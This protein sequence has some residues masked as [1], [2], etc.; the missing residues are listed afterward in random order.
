[1]KCPRCNSENPDTAYFCGACGAQLRF[2]ENTN[3]SQTETLEVSGQ[4]LATGTLFAGRYQIIEELG[5]G[6]MG[7]VY[8]AL[9][10]KLNE[11]VAL[12]LIR[13]E[14]AAESKTLERFQNELK[15]ARRISHRNIGR[16]YE[17]MEEK[18]THFITMEY[19]PGE[20]LKSAIRRFGQLPVGKCLFIARQICE[21]LAEAHRLGVVHRDLKP[22]NIMIDREGNARILDFGIARSLAEKGI[23]GEG[24]MIGTPE[25]MSPE[26]AEAR[27]VDNR[28]DIY[29]LGILL[30]E[31]LTGRVPFEGETPLGVAMKQKT[32]APP[33]PK[34]LN[35]QVPEGLARLVLRCLEKDKARRYQT[36]E[37][38]LTDLRAV[39]K[40]IPTTEMR[41][42][43][44]PLTS[45]EITFTFRVKKFLVPALAFM[46]ILVIGFVLLKVLPRKEAGG[47]PPGRPS[48]SIG[49]TWSNSVAVLPFTDLSL[50]RDQEYLCDGMT[51]DII[52]QLSRIRDL[53]V[54]SRTSV[55][56]YRNTQK[57]IKEIAREL[58]VAHILEGSI[59]RE[60]ETIR[61]NAQL[62]DAESG[63]QIW[64]A[65]YDRKLA[66]IFAI[67]DEISQAIADALRVELSADS[68]EALKAG[69][70]EN[71][72]L[73]E[74]YLQGM[75]FV[76]SRY[77]LLYREEDFIKAL[78][79]LEEAKKID[80]GYAWTY[81]GLAWAY[82][83]RYSI[84][85]QAEDLKQVVVNAEKGYRLGPDI[86]ESNMAKG[87]VH[88][89]NGE[90][91]RAFEKYRIAYE[92]DPNNLMICAAIGYSYNY[93]GLHE[94]AIPF[95]L[96]GTEL[97]PF[98]IFTKT[99]LAL[100][101]QGLGEFE[102]AEGYLREA[103]NL[104]PRNPFSLAR[105]SDCLIRVGKYD[106]AGKLLAE[107]ESVDPNL[108]FLPEY[109]A[110]FYAAREEK[111]KA[112]SLDRSAEVYSLLG[113]KDE[114]IQTMRKA[115][116]DGTR[117]P[118][119]DLIH[120]PVYK[121]LRDDP[122]FKEI[123]AGAKI[124][125]EELIKKYGN[126]FL[127]PSARNLSL[128]ISA[129][130]SSIR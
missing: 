95:L 122:R 115:I 63:F 129:R 117:F 114:A 84:T 102:K 106:E 6:G 69:R 51:E 123:V 46:A 5:K 3:Y 4:E 19:V 28:S 74:I 90:Y 22:G 41:A 75:Y 54:I 101:Y 10:R 77:V 80:P 14:I 47:P 56:F 118:Y 71:M 13:P 34:I 126:F 1:M 64:S 65:K 8:R 68:L 92:K 108:I 83:H 15:T 40:E 2:P 128:Q 124:S 58:G 31:M 107:L 85:L 119:L 59:Q 99:I 18:G 32:E 61:V 57:T 72:K 113:M 9:D 81:L 12:K 26:Q 121:N 67:Q 93:F 45:R 21:G 52:G 73:Y 120:D 70:P 116:S 17:L 91:D 110:R 55:V 25:Y 37:E 97:A 96:K 66:G 105:L 11:E 86:A 78:Q 42:S 76:N 111:E 125:H 43:R 16:M 38:L 62:I 100:C 109:K 50:Q 33:N 104:N 94:Q 27:E 79:M 88:F 89:L 29:S 87:F 127:S 82:W 103:L 48:S 49:G 20:D 35:S 112:L 30:F 24:V 53:K 60:G 39:E 130:Q 23:T 98:Y 44:K 7:R 36:A